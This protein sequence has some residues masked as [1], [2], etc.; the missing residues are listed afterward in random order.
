VLFDAMT[1]TY[2]ILL[3]LH[4]TFDVNFFCRDTGP[5]YSGPGDHGTHGIDNYVKNHRCRATRIC[6]GLMI[7]F[8]EPE[9]SHP[10]SSG[11]R[12]AR[13]KTASRRS[14][15]VN[16]HN[17]VEDEDKDEDEDEDE[18]SLQSIIVHT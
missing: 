18:D 9:E 14:D 5:E 3:S 10:K 17:G 7:E 11:T 1:H 8:K 16:S 2:V 12:Q 4:V 13:H 6:G 15:S